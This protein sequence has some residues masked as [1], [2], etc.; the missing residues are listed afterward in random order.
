MAAWK[1]WFSIKTFPHLTDDDLKVMN[2]AANVIQSQAGK[3]PTEA[4]LQ[5]ISTTYKKGM[6]VEALFEYLK[7]V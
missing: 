1:K 3:P 2:R 5:N 6:S 4:E 7:K